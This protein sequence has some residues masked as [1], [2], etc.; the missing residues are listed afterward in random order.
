M[1]EIEG[2]FSTY[3]MDRIKNDYIAYNTA[4]YIR[5]LNIL[6][7]RIGHTFLIPELLQ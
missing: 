3:E 5:R 2:I 7:D 6:L 1:H 4:N